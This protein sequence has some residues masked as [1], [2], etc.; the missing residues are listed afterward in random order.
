MIVVFDSEKKYNI[1]LSHILK[2]KNNGG[3][4]KKISTTKY[5]K[6]SLKIYI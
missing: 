2:I 3:R 6:K 5:L 4:F 1:M